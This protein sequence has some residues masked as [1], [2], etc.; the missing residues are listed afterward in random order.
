LALSDKAGTRTVGDD[1]VD[2]NAGPDGHEAQYTEDD[3]SGE[4]A[5]RAVDDRS[6]HRVSV[7]SYAGMYL[8]PYFFLPQHIIF[9]KKILC[10]APCPQ[11]NIFF[12]KIMCCGRKNKVADTYATIT[13]PDAR[14]SRLC[15]AHGQ[16]KQPFS[17]LA[18]RP[19]LES[20]SNLVGK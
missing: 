2:W 18:A 17:Q 14:L 16:H 10:C 3:D 20:S 6:D 7:T 12:E 5:R 19:A 13:S 11:H 9:K 15:N 1:F 4:H 8:P